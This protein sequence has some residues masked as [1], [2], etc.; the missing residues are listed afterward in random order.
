M[1]SMDRKETFSGEAHGR[2]EVMHQISSV[3]FP[4]R[5][6]IED[7]YSL[8]VALDWEFLGWVANY[9]KRPVS[10]SSTS[11]TRVQVPLHTFACTHTH[12]HTHTH[13][14]LKNNF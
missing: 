7:L 6:F 8:N 13:T 3:S 12:T 1:N 4:R 9:F 11:R 2:S 10:K 5:L 14:Q